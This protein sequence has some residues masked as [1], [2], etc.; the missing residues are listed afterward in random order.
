MAMKVSLHGAMEIVSHEA[1]VLTPYLDSKK[2]LTLG[3]G[4]TKAAGGI[5]P[6]RFKGALTI[7]QAFDL[8]RTDLAKFEKRVNA[9]FTVPLKQHEF[10]AAVSFDF[11]TGEIH[12]AAWVKKF[13]AGDRAGAIK[14]IMNWQKPPELK[15]RRKAEQKLFSTGVY[16]GD[17]SA[18]VYDKKPGKAR[19]VQLAT[20]LG[21]LPAPTPV[22]EISLKL[23]DVGPQVVELQQNLVTLGF[24]PFPASGTYDARTKAEVEAFQAGHKN[25]DGEPLII[26]G[27]AGPRTQRAIARELLKPKIK[28]AEKNVPPTATKEVKEKTSLWGWLTT[29]FSGGSGLGLGFLTGMDWKQIAVVGAIVLIML[30]AFLLL[31]RQI[32]ARFKEINADAR[33]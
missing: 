14:A 33:A 11:N 16:S 28:E 26:D 20:V 31:G 5:D 6:S 3:V 29:L 7:Q 24:G 22:D 25:D 13:N 32:L 19:R 17:G 30:A 1:I 15:D 21:N 4:H 12:R 9:A 8:F 23:G 18:L 2:I 10:D 27:K